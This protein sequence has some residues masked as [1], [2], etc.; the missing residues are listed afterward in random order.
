MCS[1]S[2]KGSYDVV[3]IG[4][5]MSGLATACILGRLG[6]KVLVLEQHDRAGGCLHTF[7]EEG[8]RFS[9]GNHYIGGFDETSLKLIEVCGS[10]VQKK[11]G[12]IET[13]IRNGEKKVISD[14]HSW[15]EVMG[16]APARVERMADTMWWIAFVKLAPEWL[17]YLAWLFVCIF[18]SSSF[19][20]YD[21]WMN[22]SGWCQ[23]QEGDVGCKPIAM[24]GAA[25]SRHYMDGLS[26]LSE[27]FVY[28]CCRTIKNQGGCVVVNKRVEKIKHNGVLLSD[29]VFVPAKHIVSSVGVLGTCAMA[30]LP[31]LNK[32]VTGLG[33]SV[34]HKFVFLGLQCSREDSGVPSGV[35]WISEEDQYL[36]VSSDVQGE[37]ISIHLIADNMGVKDMIALFYKHYPRARQFE[38]HL[39][40][41]SHYSVKKY[42]GRHSSYGLSC[43]GERFSTY[44]YVRMLRPDTSIPN[45]FLT[46]HDIL[47]PGIVSAL[48]TAMMTS[49][50]VMGISLVDTIMGK[51]IMDII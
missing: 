34:L 49:R 7:H 50:Q 40:S 42:L 51:D 6:K 28:D 4:S 23:M 10:S 20:Q 5:G 24:V 22:G 45:L 8:Y 39:N 27:K 18:Y 9:S 43:K 41:A 19:E 16:C 31:R 48:T 26:T 38:K 36:F 46:G 12:T 30:D 32:V 11:E 35:I 15:K 37:K 33:Q 13:F 47:M 17:A 14:R 29:S 3:V 2:I 1:R 21:S 25:V 44:K